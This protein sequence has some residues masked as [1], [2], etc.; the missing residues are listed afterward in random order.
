MFSTAYKQHYQQTV[1]LALP[2]TLGQL[3]NIL[4]AVADNM[5]V[6]NYDSQS[7]APV[8]LANSI[9][10]TILLFG[11]GTSLGLTPLIAAAAA[12][13]EVRSCQSLLKNSLLLYGF[14]GIILSLISYFLAQHLDWFNDFTDLTAKSKPFLEI[15]SFTL[16]PFMLFMSVR[17]FMEGLSF[18]KEVMYV[19][20][21]GTFCNVFL[22]Y[23]LIFGKFGFPEMGMIGAAIAT[24]ISR[25]LMLLLI[26]GVLFYRQKFKIYL[27]KINQT[28]ISVLTIKQ[29]SKIG[30]PIGMQ[31]VFEGGC[32]SF[33][34]IMIGW[35]GKNE[36]AAHQIALNVA[37]LTFLMTTGIASAAAIRVANQRGMKDKEEMIL[38]GKSAIF[39]AMGFMIF[40]AIAL[41]T[42]RFL[43]P[44]FYVDDQNI[45]NIAA[46]LM[47]VA[48]IFQLSDGVQ[49]VA[50]GVLRGMEDV[51]IPTIIA[52]ISYWVIGIPVGYFFGIYMKLGTEG[53]WLGL[54]IGL[55]VAAV[56]LYIR[57]LKISQ[58]EIK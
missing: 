36:L 4:I 52:L 3:S 8:S 39:M 35:L 5:M 54:V 22:N 46:S 11:L 30:F 15:I 9:F 27:E 34:A 17:G 32:F 14:L 31:L 51:K 2:I 53:V 28:I 1:K 16:F 48:A 12:Q 56:W 7:L 37:S 26:I 18:T 42:T 25:F 21:F 40:C 44:S 55:T 57:F 19:N 50:M 38:A 47:V 6:G 10:L 24:L 13:K 33:A 45:I 49:V 41:F 20:F 58:R 23:L 43:L 29:L